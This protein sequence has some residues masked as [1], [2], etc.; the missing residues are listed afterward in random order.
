MTAAIPAKRRNCSVVATHCVSRA[1]QFRAGETDPFNA[2]R[3]NATCYGER[4]YWLSTC[5]RGCSNHLEPL[6]FRPLP[7]SRALAAATLLAATMLAL[8]ASAFAQQSDLS[9]SPFMSFLP[10]AGASPLAGLALTLA[11]SA[12]FGLRGSVNMALENNNNNYLIT[13][14]GLRPWGADADA[15]FSLG[16]RMF[17]TGARG[18]VAPYA[19]VGVGTA[20]DGINSN[21]LHSNWS[22]G[23][24]LAIPL[25]AAIDAFGESRWR[26]SQFVLPT[27]SL[28]PSPTTEIRVGLSFHVGG[29]S[30]N[31]R[32]GARRRRDRRSEATPSSLPAGP[33]FPAPA[34]TSASAARTLGLAGQ[35]VG[36]PYRYG[37]TSPQSGFDCSGFV[38]YV[39]AEQ[40]V[41]LPR[42]SR[43]QARVGEALSPDWRALSAGD[44][45]MFAENGQISHV[46]IYAGHNR[47]IH[48]S[49][50]GGGVRY[51]DLSTQRGE[52][53]VDHMVAARRV[54]PDAGGFVLDLARGFAGGAT[55]PLDQPD[56]APK[57][58]P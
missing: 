51:D 25:G 24:G 17:G 18:G 2:R 45:V 14:T 16:G 30:A 21:G 27:A 50:S 57:P 41:E 53:F 22:Y 13:G 7:T 55:A 23:A 39:F 19:F 1:G 5:N 11:G 8:P 28:A 10:S 6:V 40:G 12:G 47:I 32:G 42:T 36:V 20:S 9:I 43:E 4:R 44:L 3:L 29:K 35:S 46:A 38:Q 54:T 33:R 15:V 56:H 49:S 26:M 34:T 58:T 48:S 52:W 31:T 37:G